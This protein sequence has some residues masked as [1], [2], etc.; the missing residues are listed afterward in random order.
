MDLY[1]LSF[2]K[3]TH[4]MSTNPQLFHDLYEEAFKALNIKVCL[5]M[6]MF[7]IIKFLQI[8]NPLILKILFNRLIHFMVLNLYK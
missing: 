3:V 7:F 8:Q 6:C 4:Q 5:I 1:L 2:H